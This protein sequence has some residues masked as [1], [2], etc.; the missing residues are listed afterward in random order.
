MLEGIIARLYPEINAPLAAI[1]THE[2]GYIV[3][4]FEEDKRTTIILLGVVFERM[5]QSI[6]VFDE[7]SHTKVL[8]KILLCLALRFRLL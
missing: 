6:H 4:K 5:C 8:K 7:Y 3:F 2:H 1:L